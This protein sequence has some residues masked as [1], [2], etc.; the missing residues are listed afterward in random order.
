MTYQ[1][2][3][4]SGL[5]KGGTQYREPHLQRAPF[6]VK[7]VVYLERLRDKRP[8]AAER[9]NMEVTEGHRE[10]ATS[11]PQDPLFPNILFSEKGSWNTP[12]PPRGDSE[13]QTA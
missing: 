5:R 11:C 6:L 13:G 4:K 12:G 1:R 10:S 3:Q 7:M 2:G 8:K 9:F